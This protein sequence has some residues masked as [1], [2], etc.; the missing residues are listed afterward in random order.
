MKIDK[1]NS[2]SSR[3]LKSWH[4]A[5]RPREKLFQK[6]SAHLTS[7]ELLAIL[8]G[9]GNAKENA[10]QLSQRILSSVNYNLVHLSKMGLS[11]LTKFKG[12]GMTKAV[13]I[14]AAL[15]LGRR[16]QR[17]ETIDSPQVK[18]S[19]DAYQYIKTYVED[20]NHEEFWILLLN[21]SNKII[22]QI[23]ISKGGVSGTIVDPKLVFKPA[24]QKSASGII[25]THNHP[26]GNLNP[27][28]DDIRLT[29]KIKV[30]GKYLELEVLDHLIVT[31][32]GYY[33][34]ADEGTL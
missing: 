30:A 29:H 18:S 19:K 10:V 27:S 31:S 16:R 14:A 21:R 9:K 33:S 3:S 28:K 24:L 11:E 22:D 15:E 8:I 5:D 2:F 13:T 32:T 17:A 34:F 20:L 25:L 23:L 4:I 1:K 26:S 12:I 7:S 6:G